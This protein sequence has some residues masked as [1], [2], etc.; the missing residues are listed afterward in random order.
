MDTL[1]WLWWGLSGAALLLRL[2]APVMAHTRV[3]PRA[4]L[5]H[6]LLGVGIGAAIAGAAHAE[7]DRHVIPW[8]QTGAGFRVAS[9][10]LPEVIHAV[11]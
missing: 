8:W 9:A 1:L 10:L 5:A 4:W 6:G 2:A 11:R 7:V 3:R